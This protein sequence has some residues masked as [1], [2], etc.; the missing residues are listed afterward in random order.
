M[1][2]ALKKYIEDRIIYLK[3]IETEYWN[4]RYNMNYPFY[5]REF[6]KQCEKDFE[7]RR[8]ELEKLLADFNPLKDKQ[9]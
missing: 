5:E 7:S 3:G 4:K 8:K 6:Y 9:N 2:E 1:D